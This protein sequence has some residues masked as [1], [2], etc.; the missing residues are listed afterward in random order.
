MIRFMIDESPSSTE[1]ISFSAYEND[2]KIGNCVFCVNGYEM[3][4][5]SVNCADDIVI[6]GLAR[7]AMN[8]AANRNAYIAKIPSSLV[9]PAFTRLGFEGDDI[10]SVEIPE[11]L[12]C[13]CGCHGAN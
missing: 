3:V 5:F 6:E 1:N 13:G 11:A 12:A 8:Y 7:A 10:L 9:C 4:F 2:E